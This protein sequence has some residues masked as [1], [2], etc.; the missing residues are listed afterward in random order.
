[1][2]NKINEVKKII[3]ESNNIVFLGEQEYQ[4][5]L[6]FQILDLQLDFIIEKIIH[7]IRLNIC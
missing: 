2:D 6:A 3:K 1:M 7:H 5:H 4:Q